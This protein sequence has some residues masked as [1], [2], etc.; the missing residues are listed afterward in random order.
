M[1]TEMLLNWVFVSF[2]KITLQIEVYNDTDY[3]KVLFYNNYANGPTTVCGN[4]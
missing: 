1:V 2:F 4:H 3:V